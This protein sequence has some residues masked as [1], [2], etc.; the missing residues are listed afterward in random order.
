MNLWKGRINPDPSDLLLFQLIHPLDMSHDLFTK[1]TD[2]HTAILGFASDEGV[3]RNLG[4][5]GARKAPEMIRKVCAGLAV[6]FDKNQMSVYDAGNI[7]CTGQKLEAAQRHLAEKVLDLL[8]QG[9]QPLILGG[10][11]E[12]SFGHYMG[13]RNFVSK[14]K[15]IGIINFDA[16]FDVRS[17][18]RGAHSGSPFRQIAEMDATFHYLPIGIRPESNIA[19]L[20][21]FMYDHGQSFIQLGEVH[22]QFEEVRRQIEEFCE[23]VDF[24]Y[25]TIDMDC[26]PAAYAPGV[27]AS[28]PDGILPYHAVEMIRCIRASKK[29]L[30]SDIVETNPEYD[31]D[32]RTIKLAAEL[33]FHLLDR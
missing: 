9:I 8:H 10:G 24:V 18:E 21:Q 17:Y 29:L 5:L 16:H 3:R 12:T 30:S 31:I 27:S 20:M 22:G 28:A 7:L 19:S 1:D 4:R 23:S 11:H 26:F 6:H 15:T 25:L 32:N 33:M 13:L 14:D 2:N